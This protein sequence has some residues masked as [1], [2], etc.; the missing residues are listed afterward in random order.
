MT[1]ENS[2]TKMNL[3][4]AFEAETGAYFRYTLYADRARKAGH[5]AVGTL[6]DQ[7]ARNEWAHAK[8]WYKQLN[9]E[10]T[11]EE[12]LENAAGGEHYEWSEMYARWADVA[13]EEGE[14]RAEWLFRQVA[15]ACVIA[16]IRP[17]NEASFAPS[18]A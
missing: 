2:Q 5:H 1:N 9:G 14:T 15:A 8:I 3:H 6:F 16:D 4:R 7:I 13:R 10:V 17:E 18:R 12:A 11:V